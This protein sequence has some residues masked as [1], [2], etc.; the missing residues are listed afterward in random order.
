[1][2]EQYQKEISTRL[3]RRFSASK[4]GYTVT[5]KERFQLEGFINAGIF[6]ELVSA[7]EVQALIEELH[8]KVFDMSI[9]EHQNKKQT[10][11]T[12]LGMDYSEFESPAWLRK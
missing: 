5:D 2:K 6:L 11:W 7:A 8:Q 1:M 4:Q 3:E 12:A 9:S 10:S